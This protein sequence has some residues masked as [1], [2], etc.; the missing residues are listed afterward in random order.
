MEK[1]EQ[2]LT[3]DVHNSEHNFQFR[4]AMELFRIIYVSFESQEGF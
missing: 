2:H 4:S 1:V 3:C